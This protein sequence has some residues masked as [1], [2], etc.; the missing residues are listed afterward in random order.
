M[1]VASSSFSAIA[2]ELERLHLRRE[3]V[4]NGGFQALLECCPRLGALLLEGLGDARRA[5]SWLS[6]RQRAFSGRT[7]WD[8]LAEGDE[9]GV[10]DVASRLLHVSVED[11]VPPRAAGVR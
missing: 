9:D 1:L 7:A 8:L 5:A 11:D 4:I 10:W 2:T 3:S 6:S